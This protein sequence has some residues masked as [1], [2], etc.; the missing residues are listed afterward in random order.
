MIRWL[1][2]GDVWQWGVG[3]WDGGGHRM[4]HGPL[5]LKRAVG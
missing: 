4:Q 1:G 3:G 5:L 2:R